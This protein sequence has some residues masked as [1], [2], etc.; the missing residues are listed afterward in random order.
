LLAEIFTQQVGDPVS[1]HFSQHIRPKFTDIRHQRP[2]LFV[3]LA[4]DPDFNGLIGGRQVFFDLAFDNAA[5]LFNHQNLYLAADEVHS[6]MLF[7]WPDQA[8]FVD[9]NTQCAQLRFS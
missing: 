7:Q 8:D 1:N 4:D 6:A 5:L 3:M 2:T 9:I